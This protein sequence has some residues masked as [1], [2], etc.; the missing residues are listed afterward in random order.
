MQVEL[1]DDVSEALKALAAKESRSCGK[2]ASVILRGHFSAIS[3]NG[4]QNWITVIPKV[5]PIT[6]KLPK[7]R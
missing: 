2:Q 4:T 7:K 3:D 5:H 1:D 6:K